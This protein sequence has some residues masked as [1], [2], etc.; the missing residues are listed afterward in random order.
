MFIVFGFM[1]Q[2]FGSELI[3]QIKYSESALKLLHPTGN[4]L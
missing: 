2:A 1:N 3:L 4:K